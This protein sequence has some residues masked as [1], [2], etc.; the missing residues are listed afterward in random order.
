M[1]VRAVCSTVIE[2][3][4]LVAMLLDGRKRISSTS[5]LCDDDVGQEKEL[6]RWTRSSKYLMQTQ[7][8][9]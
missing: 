8:T 6:D 7:D 1:L 4:W 9:G 5:M 2:P 3:C